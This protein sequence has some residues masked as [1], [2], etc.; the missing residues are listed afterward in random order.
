M[1]TNRSQPFALGI[2]VTSRTV[3]AVLLQQGEDGP[4]IV[5]RFTRQRAVGAL[6]AALGQTPESDQENAGEDFTIQFGD[7]P[8][9]GSEMFLHSE[10]AGLEANGDQGGAQAMA[11]FDLELADILAECR[12]A[13]YA[14]PHLA[15]AV[16]SNDVV[17]IE[18]RVPAD[19]KKKRPERSKLL[20]ILRQQHDGPV[21]DDRVSFLAM[22]SSEEG[23]Y[24][25]L[26]FLP[27]PNDVVSRTL[28]EIK[29]QKDVRMPAVR[30]VDTETSL[31]LGIARSALRLQSDVPGRD[32][33]KDDEKKAPPEASE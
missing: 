33:Q 29:R 19:N 18:L 6:Q 21:D 30:L 26:A 2:M 31:Y 10:F 13:G 9:G 11:G 14:D 28:D 3:E 27:Q 32:A 24:R 25:Y 5:R 8:G 1:K 15:F 12:D 23:E 20:K 4:A 7:A 17:Q 16:G 22:T